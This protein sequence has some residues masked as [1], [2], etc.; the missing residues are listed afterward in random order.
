M[1]TI[2]LLVVALLVATPLPCCSGENTRAAGLIST[3]LP[4]C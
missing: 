2:R 1:K 4:S 3:A